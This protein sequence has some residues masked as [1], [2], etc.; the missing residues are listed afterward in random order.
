MTTAPAY[1]LLLTGGT[2]I[3]P[4]QGIDGRRDIA[5]KD[6][7]VAEVSDRIDPTTANASLDITGKLVTPGLIDIHGHF[8][9]GGNQT[10][11]HPDEI[12]LSSG[13]T[14][15]VDAGSAGFIN[16]EAM[17]D[18]VFPAHRTRLLS[19]LHVSG[20]GL[21][22]NRLLGGGLHDMR[23]IDVDQTLSLIHI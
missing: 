1:D 3:D 10:A 21:A 6:G 18:Y 14:T 9:H 5:F 12:C 15:G 8:Y 17:R 11:V 19:F 16:Y 7:L 22:N 4:A 13:T 2:M 20:V 23:M